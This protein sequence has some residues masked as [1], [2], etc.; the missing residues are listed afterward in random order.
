MTYTVKHYQ[1]AIMISGVGYHLSVNVL[2]SET[3]TDDV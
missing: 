2:L 3:S 1:L